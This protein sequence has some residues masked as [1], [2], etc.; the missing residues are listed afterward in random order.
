MTPSKEESKSQSRPADEALA[1]ANRPRRRT[2]LIGVIAL[3]AVVLV[4]TLAVMFSGSKTATPETKTIKGPVD[5]VVPGTILSQITNIPASVYD[6]VGVTSPA[7]KV[8]PPLQVTGQ[9]PLTYVVNGKPLPGVLYVG[10]EYSPFSAVQRWGLVAA[11]SRFGSWHGLQLTKSSS[12]D[13]FAGTSTFSFLKASLSSPYVALRA[14]ELYGNNLTGKEFNQLE[15][16]SASD[17]ANFNKYDNAK[18]VPGALT[19]GIPFTNFNNEFFYPGSSFPPL[20]FK[21]LSWATIAGNLSNP[22]VPTTQA[23]V[24]SA[25]YMTA[26]ICQST[27][28]QPGSVCDS[29]GVK[30]AESAMGL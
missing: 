12:Q 1:E 30:A 20:V 15:T 2:A 7:V 5:T 3:V 26:A 17:L 8:R 29:A 23:V 6:T 19:H 21:K 11:L 10:A 28:G 9:P 24:A 27:N 13:F 4:A 18:V 16:L 25:N 14:Y 22:N